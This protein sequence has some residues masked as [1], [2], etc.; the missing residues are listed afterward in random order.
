[1]NSHMTKLKPAQ[2]KSET[3]NKL[4]HT[5]LQRQYDNV[6]IINGRNAELKEGG[7]MEC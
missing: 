3:L 1:M 6:N 4:R 5:E 7:V 2:F